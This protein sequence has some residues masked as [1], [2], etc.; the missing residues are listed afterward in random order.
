MRRRTGL[1]EIEIVERIQRQPIDRQRIEFV[2]DFGEHPML[3]ETPI[4]E[5]AEIGENPLR[6]GMENMW[7]VR[8]NENSLCIVAV[9]SIAANMRPSVEDEYALAA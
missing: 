7:A 8:V 9:K 6:V 2:A 1:V 3:V 5:T 4:G